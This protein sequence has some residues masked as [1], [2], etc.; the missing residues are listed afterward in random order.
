MFAFVCCFYVTL[1]SYIKKLG[2]K[3]NS[4]ARTKFSSS[5]SLDIMLFFSISKYIYSSSSHA[6]RTVQLIFRVACR[7]SSVNSA[8]SCVSICKGY[9]V[10]I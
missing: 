2:S 6:C 3:W 9:Y 7:K 1:T 8:R 10:V 4:G 5:F